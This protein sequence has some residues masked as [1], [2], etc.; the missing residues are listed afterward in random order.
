MILASTDV[1]TFCGKLCSFLHI[2]YMSLVKPLHG[3]ILIAYTYVLGLYL[4]D[5]FKLF[6]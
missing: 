5:Y 2:L 6:R 1:G 4:R 3:G